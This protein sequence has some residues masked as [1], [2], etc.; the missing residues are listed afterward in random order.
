MTAL[1]SGNP[2]HHSL[3]Q[4]RRLLY[5]ILCCHCSNLQVA[6]VSFQIQTLAPTNW[7]STFLTA[8]K[9]KLSPM[10][11]N[12]HELSSWPSGIVVMHSFADAVEETN[13]LFVSH[14]N[15]PK[16]G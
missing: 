10:E 4:A 2:V 13:L 3:K 8:K 6:D 11:E 12:S 9:N 7:K 1:T 16:K 5:V 14:I 15:I